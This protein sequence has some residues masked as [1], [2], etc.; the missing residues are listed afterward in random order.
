VDVL[1]YEYL[2]TM[3]AAAATMCRLDG[4]LCLLGA[5]GG[6]RVICV[7]KAGSFHHVILHSFHVICLVKTQIDN[8][9]YVPWPPI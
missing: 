8:S 1:G 4:G 9:Q 7:G 2:R 6:Q 5:G 3:T